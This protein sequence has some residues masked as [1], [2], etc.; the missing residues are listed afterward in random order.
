MCAM[1]RRRELL[2][3]EFRNFVAGVCEFVHEHTPFR[4]IALRRPESIRVEAWG[5]KNRLLEGN[6]LDCGGQLIIMGVICW[7]KQHTFWKRKFLA[8]AL[9][10]VFTQLTAQV[11]VSTMVTPGICPPVKR[12]LE[13]TSFVPIHRVNIVSSTFNLNDP[14]DF[15]CKNSGSWL[16]KT[17]GNGLDVRLFE[18]VA[19]ERAKGWS[20]KC[21]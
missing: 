4:R 12:A 2:E 7:Q 19:P 18:H 10:S 1:Q 8:P 3:H 15:S 21:P 6:H 17:D 20:A 9:Y 13:P 16:S 14:F 11:T 5:V